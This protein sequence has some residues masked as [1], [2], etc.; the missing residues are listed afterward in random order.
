MFAFLDPNDTLALGDER[1]IPRCTQKQYPRAGSQTAL[2]VCVARAG[3]QGTEENCGVRG[4]AYF[5]I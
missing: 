1:I 5:R 2:D 4:P 3:L